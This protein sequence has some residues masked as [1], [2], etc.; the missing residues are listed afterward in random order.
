MV[1]QPIQNDHVL[2]WGIV[3]GLAFT[4]RDQIFVHHF[5]LNT[6]RPCL[7]SRI[8]KSQCLRI[9]VNTANGGTIRY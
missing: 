2:Q 7:K 5:D 4:Q 3:G 1:D 9:S 6:R 8:Y